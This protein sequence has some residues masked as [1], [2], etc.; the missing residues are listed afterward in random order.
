MTHVVDIGELTT[1]SLL[2]CIA[3]NVDQNAKTLDGEDVIHM[4]GQMGPI[5]PARPRKNSIQ[6]LKV[7]LGG[8]SQNGATYNHISKGSQ[9]GAHKYQMHQCLY[10]FT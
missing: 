6:R 4:M 3:D 10:I 2:H 1:D 9:G 5:T 7:T 8:D